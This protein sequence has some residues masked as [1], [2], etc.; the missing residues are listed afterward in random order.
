MES[1][2]SD[3]EF[4]FN[5]LQLE[6]AASSA[7]KFED[8]QLLLWPVA[9]FAIQIENKVFFEEFDFTVVEFASSASK[10]L[11]KGGDFEFSSM[12]SDL[13]PML[14]FYRRPDGNFMPYAAHAAFATD[15]FIEHGALVKALNQ[16]IDRLKKTAFEQLGLRVEQVV[17]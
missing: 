9:D 7:G 16:F 14:A 5:Q 2:P 4:R 10:W 12:E 3:V 6:H 13:N 1:M 8:W 15:G 11:R 17:K